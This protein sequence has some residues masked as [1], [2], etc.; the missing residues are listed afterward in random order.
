LQ[1]GN[2]DVSHCDNLL[3]LELESADADVVYTYNIIGLPLETRDSDV[4]QLFNL[5]GLVLES[6]NADATRKDNLMAM[7][8]EQPVLPQIAIQQL[9]TTDQ[10]GNAKTGFQIGSIVQIRFAVTNIG[11]AN[12]PSGLISVMVQDPSENVV[13]LGFTYESLASGQSREFVF[14]L[15]VS[16]GS[17]IGQHTVTAMVFTRWPY[18]GGEGLAVQTT[19]FDVSL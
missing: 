6:N 1:F 7:L 8:M 9:S 16:Y 10:S 19:Y 12:L 17:V 4:L 5:I 2:A 3:F 13:F 15:A 14:G 18:Q 11:S